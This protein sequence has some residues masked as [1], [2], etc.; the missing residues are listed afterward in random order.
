MLVHPDSPD[1]SLR[2]RFAF[3]PSGPSRHNPAT[4]PPRASRGEGRRRLRPRQTAS[5]TGFPGSPRTS[6]G[7][8]LGHTGGCTTTKITGDRGGPSLG[9][10]RTWKNKTEVHGR[11]GGPTPPRK[12]RPP[13]TGPTPVGARVETGVY[14]GDRVGWDGRDG[15]GHKGCTG[16]EESVISEDDP[17]HRGSRST[18]R[19]WDVRRP[20][21]SHVEGDLNGR[22][23]VDETLEGSSKYERDVSSRAPG[24][25]LCLD[26]VQTQSGRRT[27]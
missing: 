22:V 24:P 19:I 18:D 9:L 4:T 11:A 15:R 12:E 8:G 1:P 10:A 13:G 16:A 7:G 27:P 6:R 21:G 2:C 14:V 26:G 23:R 20:R 5:T 17:C 3:R 25:V